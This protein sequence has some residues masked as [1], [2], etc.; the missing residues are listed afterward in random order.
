MPQEIFQDSLK[1]S[2]LTR[3]CMENNSNVTG[4]GGKSCFSHT[5]PSDFPRPVRS[6]LLRCMA[7]NS[8]LT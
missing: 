6:L 5:N 4:R 1:I 3:I 2:K 7:E 8:Q